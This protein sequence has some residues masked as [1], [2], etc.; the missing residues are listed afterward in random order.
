MHILVACLCPMWSAGC[1][2]QSHVCMPF[3]PVVRPSARPP[4]SYVH[5]SVRTSV[6]PFTSI[7][8]HACERPSVRASERVFVSICPCMRVNLPT[9]KPTNQPTNLPTYLPTNLPTNPPRS[10]PTNLPTPTYLHGLP[11][12]SMRWREMKWHRMMMMHNI[13]IR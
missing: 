2:N 12:C 9:C 7:H 11:L 5:P 10:H 6:R 3:R 4:R 8:V 1:A 13:V